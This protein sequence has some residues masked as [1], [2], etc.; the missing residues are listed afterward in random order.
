M[1]AY[2]NKT[3]SQYG[4]VVESQIDLLANVSVD[5][6]DKYYIFQNVETGQFKL[7]IKQSG[8]QLWYNVQIEGEWSEDIPLTIDDPDELKNLPIYPNLFNSNTYARM[9]QDFRLYFEGGQYL[10]IAPNVPTVYFGETLRF[11]VED[12]AVVASVSQTGLDMNANRITSLANPAAA[13][14]AVNR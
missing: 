14:D 9:D 2:R 12:S 7:K 8:T 5:M 1:H 4:Q 13:T 3:V 11:A 6:K 10:R